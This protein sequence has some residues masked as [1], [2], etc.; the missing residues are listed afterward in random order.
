MLSVS[1]LAA[2]A[3]LFITPPDSDLLKNID[4]R[5]LATLFMLLSVLEGFKQE[6]IFAPLLRRTSRLSKMKKEDSLSS[7]TAHGKIRPPSPL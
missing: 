4:W 3:S 1:L 5:T 2:I 6:N 7:K